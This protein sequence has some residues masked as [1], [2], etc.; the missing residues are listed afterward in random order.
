MGKYFGTDGIR[1]IAGSELDPRLAFRTGQAVAVALSKGK[2][3]RPVITIGKDTRISSD[4]LEAALVAGMC[5][6]GA[7]V[8]LLGVVPTPAVAFLTL[9]FGADAGIVIS[10]SHNPYEHNGIKIFSADGFKLS[11]DLESEI[12]V[13]IDESGLLPMKT[14]NEIGRVYHVDA[15][16]LALYVDYL[17][18]RA[19]SEIKGLRVVIGLRQR[20]GF[21]YG[22]KPVFKIRH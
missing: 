7:D 10:A 12:E 4:M 19:E 8:R 16:A 3:G 22:A 1:G 17:Y 2:T 5:S 6:A 15:E 14:E 9:K 13:L 18:A 21:K 11:D 20:R